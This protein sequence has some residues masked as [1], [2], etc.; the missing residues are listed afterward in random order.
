M[1]AFRDKYFFLS[2]FYSAPVTY[3]GRTYLNNEAA[4]QAQKTLNEKEKEKFTTLNPSQAKYLGRRVKLRPDWEE[5][6]DEIMFEI[7]YAKFSQNVNLGERLIRTGTDYLCEEND[8]GDRY[9]GTV[10]G[11]GKN[12]LGTI[13]MMIRDRLFKDNS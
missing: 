3:R 5:V 9:W 10:N 7:C 2:N 11:V 4:F 13:L 1:V 12:K 6:K 8:W